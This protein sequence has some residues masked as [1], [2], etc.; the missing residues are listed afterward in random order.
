MEK[1]YQIQV[2]EEHCT[3]C[4]RCQLG[5]SDAYTKAF[6]QDVARIRVVVSEVDCSISFIDE[7]RKCGICADNCL[8]GALTKAPKEATV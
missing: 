8:Y 3:F 5:C 6:N 2:A 7:C 4:L 1:K